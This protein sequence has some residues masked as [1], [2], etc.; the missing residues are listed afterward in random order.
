M[1]HL[2]QVITLLIAFCLCRFPDEETPDDSRK[3]MPKPKKAPKGGKGEKPPSGVG[4]NMAV[5]TAPAL[6]HTS[7]KRSQESIPSTPIYSTTPASM[8]EPP[9]RA[10]QPAGRGSRSGSNTDDMYEVD[11][12]NTPRYD[13]LIARH[14]SLKKTAPVF[15][16]FTD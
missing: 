3:L 8:Y 9:P 2:F 15:D 5:G 12:E 4:P 16:P 14:E 6:Q 7:T 10:T 11:F 1:L 13:A